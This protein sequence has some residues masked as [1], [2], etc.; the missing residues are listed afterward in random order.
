MSCAITQNTRGPSCWVRLYCL[1]CTYT[2]KIICYTNKCFSYTQVLGISLIDNSPLPLPLRAAKVMTWRTLA[3]NSFILAHDKTGSITS[4]GS[5]L[6]LVNYIT[7]LITYPS[8]LWVLN[9]WSTHPV[10]S[11]PRP[12]FIQSSSYPTVMRAWEGFRD[13]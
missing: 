8:W 12:P 4:I 1:A 13:W 3:F 9:Q 5:Y 6:Q 2:H 7:V 10:D 11:A